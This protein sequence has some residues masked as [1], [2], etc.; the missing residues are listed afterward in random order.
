MLQ[1]G[2]LAAL[3]CA[4]LATFALLALGLGL[5]DWRVLLSRL[6]RLPA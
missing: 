1:M 5:A 6:R 2:A 3:I 4:G